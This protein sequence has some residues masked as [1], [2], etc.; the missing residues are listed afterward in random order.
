MVPELRHVL[1]LAVEE[2]P[3]VP[4]QLLVLGHGFLPQAEALVGPGQALDRLGLRIAVPRELFGEAVA[5]QRLLGIGLPGG[6]G[7]TPGGFGGAELC[8]G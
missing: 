3:A 4:D 6:L 8:R 5:L 1:A 2:L 7:G